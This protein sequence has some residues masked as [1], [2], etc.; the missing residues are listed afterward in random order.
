MASIYGEYS[1]YNRLRIDYSYSQ[2]IANNCTYINMD[3]YVERT[4]AYNYWNNYGDAYWNLTGKSNT[5]MTFD[6]A[7]GST[8]MYLG[9]SST[10]VYHNADGTGGVTLSGYW[11][12]GISGKSYIPNS[13]SVSGYISL[14]TIPRYAAITSFKCSS[15]TIN[16][17]VLDYA[18][19]STCD[20]FWYSLNGG[21]WTSMPSNKT[22]TGLSAATAYSIKLRVRR[23][24]SQ[25][26]TDSSAISVTTYD[27]AKITSASNYNIGTNTSISFSN[28]SGSTVNAWIEK[29][30]T[31]DLLS[32]KRT[33]IS[34]PYTFA[35]TSS[36]NNL[37]YAA[38][39]TANS[40]KVKFVVQTVCNGTSYYSTIIKT[41]TLT[42]ANPTF[43]NF[44]FQDSNSTTVA[45][46]GNNQKLISGY[47]NL[48]T[49]ISTANKAVA[50]KGA[51]MIKY[52]TELGK[53]S[54]E[55]SYSSSA[56]V[57][58]EL[59]KVN[60][61]SIIVKAIDGRGNITSVTKSATLV[62]YTEAVIQSMSIIRQ[63][64]IGT[65]AN[66]VGN[67]TYA[68]IN[69]GA[70][71]NAIQSIQYRVKTK[72]GS[73]GSWTDIT[74]KFTL[75]SGTFKNNT[76]SNTLTGFT[77]GT[78]YIA[79]IKVTDLLS[80]VTRQV[81]ITSGDSILC[82]NR[83][84]KLVGVGKIPTNTL[85]TGSL[86]VKGKVYAG[87]QN[88]QGLM[89]ATIQ[90]IVV[91][92]DADTYY[93]VV[94]SRTKVKSSFPYCKFNITR[95][96]SVTAPDTWNTATH[97]GGL[98]FSVLWSGDNY[99]GGNDKNLKV[100]EFGET[101]STM[102]AGMKLSTSGLVV[103]L[104]GGTATYYLE[105]DYGDF[106]SATV[107]LDGFTDNASQ[108]FSARTS[109]SNVANEIQANVLKKAGEL[110]PVGSIY[111]STVS[112]N[113]SSY[114][115]GTWVAFAT[116]RTL[117]G[118]NTGDTDFA[119]SEKTGGSKTHTLTTAQ[120]PSHSHG[121]NAHAHSFSA[122]TSSAGAHTHGGVTKN[123]ALGSYEFNRP[124]GW[125]G[126]YSR[127]FT[128]SAGAHTHS[129]S[130]TTGGNS[131]NT[132]ATGSSGAHNNLQPYIV[133]YMF[134]RTA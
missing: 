10:T 58:M 72:S 50:N 38:I 42:D 71:T 30:T 123:G 80:S 107:Y 121:L 7:A 11:Y 52:R 78:E 15:K 36:D 111:I 104:R 14:P 34:S 32:A 64:G 109:T 22:I 12:T 61:S 108:T 110:Y 27:Y 40:L 31:T 16:S 129:V 66:I 130:G 59:T 84:K 97:R 53:L 131:G 19:D 62:N 115:G 81:E 1:N 119:S 6:W 98:T 120:I 51:T 101:Y 105:S 103:W 43:S 68:N 41:A 113:P 67:G 74:S 20:A 69:F 65:T 21:S 99:W 46:T 54:K 39:P 18:V 45:L 29:E 88:I 24:D 9:S 77:V 33:G 56:E 87:G 26:T 127:T 4:Q 86:D 63:N 92:G 44:T 23:K 57:S 102:V 134:K 79:E 90:T 124:N 35:W 112:T 17:L 94:I 5:Y 25:L 93:P 133:V 118:I 3:L 75:G 100:L 60:A 13:I 73:F 8:S 114:F 122:T 49:I 117:V 48:K 116:G 95:G 76:T 37:H 91:G 85:P 126:D 89:G 82:L 128:D 47:S 55:V 106:V 125:S 70:K 132:T 96:F 28:P 2:S 83:T